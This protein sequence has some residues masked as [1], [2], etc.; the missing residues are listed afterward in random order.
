VAAVDPHGQATGSI[1]IA[2]P[3]QPAAVRF[4]ITSRVDKPS[5]R[6][7]GRPAQPSDW[8]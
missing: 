4:S 6:R 2:P 1:D 5:K 8:F 3:T 7:C